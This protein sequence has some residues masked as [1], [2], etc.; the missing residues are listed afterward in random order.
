M[1]AGGGGDAGTV[2]ILVQTRLLLH[3]TL[4]ALIS[5]SS[6]SIPHLSQCPRVVVVAGAGVVTEILG[7][8]TG[9]VVD[10]LL[11]SCAVRHDRSST[12]KQN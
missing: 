7:D 10:S 11:S 5:H 2:G 12:R 8:V 1:P 4:H 3:W 9:V 6:S